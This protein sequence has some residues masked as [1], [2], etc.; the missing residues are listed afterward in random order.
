MDNNGRAVA[1]QLNDWFH[2]ILH[3]TD[4]SFF[5]IMPEGP[6]RDAVVLDV[7]KRHARM[8]S[9]SDLDTEGKLYSP[10][11][12]FLAAACRKL[13]TSLG[14]GHWRAAV[15]NLV[16]LRQQ[17][18]SVRAESAEV[19]LEIGG[20]ASLFRQELSEAINQ[21]ALNGGV[22]YLSREDRQI[23][24]ALSI[25]WG[26]RLLLAYAV[27]CCGWMAPSNRKDLA[28]MASLLGPLLSA[29]GS[30]PLESKLTE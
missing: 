9:G 26:I 3:I 11:C 27:D 16:H 2:S 29:P 28:W 19:G 17:L 1:E 12:L 30:Q 24:L 21:A 15:D 13:G 25:N 20:P 23:A 6:H 14:V 4:E 5:S 8:L 10:L 22:S 18:I 7:L